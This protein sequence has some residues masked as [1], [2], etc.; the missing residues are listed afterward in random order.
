MLVAPDLL[1]S[2]ENV[3]KTRGLCNDVIDFSAHIGK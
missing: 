2:A 1:S 3:I